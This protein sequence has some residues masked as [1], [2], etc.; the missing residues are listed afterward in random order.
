M[1]KKIVNPYWGNE[2][3]TQV[4][5]TFEYEDGTSLT[6]S[7]MNSDEGVDNN[8]DW[9]QLFTEHTVEGIDKVSEDAR[10]E[11]AAKYKTNKASNAEREK[12]DKAKKQNED[13]FQAKL[14]AFTI[15]EIKSSTD[16]VLKAKI[17]KATTLIEVIAYSTQLIMKE[18]ENETTETET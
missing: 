15:A 17:R 13:I 8:P 4:V 5:C 10:N 7:V 11:G 6:A 9:D 16:R 2:E 12:V 18:S 3:K 1:N 14:D